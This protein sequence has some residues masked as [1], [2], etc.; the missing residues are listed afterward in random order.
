MNLTTLINDEASEIFINTSDYEMDFGGNVYIVCNGVEYTFNGIRI[1]TS[2]CCGLMQ[3]I[4]VN[5]I[6]LQFEPT[7]DVFLHL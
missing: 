5:N 2:K 4:V 1:L 3:P 7:D 6:S